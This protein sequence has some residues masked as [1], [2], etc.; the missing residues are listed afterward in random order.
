MKTD[1]SKREDEAQNCD[2]EGSCLTRPVRRFVR[3]ASQ[4]AW[5]EE[6]ECAH[7]VRT[8]PECKY[9]MRPD[10]TS[11]GLKLW[12]ITE[13]GVPGNTPKGKTHLTMD[14]EWR[15]RLL[16]HVAEGQWCGNR[17]IPPNTEDRHE[18]KQSQPTKGKQ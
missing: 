10:G 11:R 13:R 7:Y 5:R 6:V 1:T 18:A 14:R 16:P 12:Y 17:F 2:A 3:W 9:A 4:W 8:S 15:E